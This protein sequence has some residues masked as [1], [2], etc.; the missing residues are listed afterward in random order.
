MY[1]LLL[2]VFVLNLI[3]KLLLINVPFISYDILFILS[4]LL[5]TLYIIYIWFILKNNTFNYG[6]LSNKKWLILSIL[7]TLLCFLIVTKNIETEILSRYYLLLVECITVG[8]LEEFLFRYIAFDYFFSKSKKYAHTAVLVSLLFALF[9]IS[10]LFTGSSIFSVI[11]QIE[12][13]FL[14]GLLLQ[15]VFLKTSNLIIVSTI[16]A[17]INFIGSNTSLANNNIV[18]HISFH[19]FILN[20]LLILIIYL[21]FIPIYNWGLKNH[22]N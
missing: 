22:L 16:H 11:N 13:A 3:L 18:E 20:Q 19:D 2:W 7:I 1:K 12:V 14:L 6:I 8:F 9:H 15:F 21:I 10:N 5:L 17:L 4:R